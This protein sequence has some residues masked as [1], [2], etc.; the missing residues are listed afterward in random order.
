SKCSC[1]AALSGERKVGI[2]V[3]DQ[4]RISTQLQDD[5]L[6]TRVA[7]DCPTDR[8]ATREADHL[9]TVIR[10]SSLLHC[11]GQKD[12]TERRL[13]CGLQHQRTPGGNRGGYLVSHQVQRKIERSNARDRPQ[14]KAAHDA[15]ASDGVFLPV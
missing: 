11:F 14:R 9:Q 5:L 13:W 4:G 3:N 7:L 6:L 1:H 12:G 2:A 15:P 8:S 10:P